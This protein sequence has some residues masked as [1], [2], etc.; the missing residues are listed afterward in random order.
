MAHR[1]HLNTSAAHFKCGQD[2]NSHG[3]KENFV[4]DTRKPIKT[5]NRRIKDAE[6]YHQ[7]F[8]FPD[9]VT[10]QKEF[11]YGQARINFELNA[12]DKDV[13]KTLRVLVEA[14][15]KLKNRPELTGELGAIDFT[16]ICAA[17]NDAEN[18][19]NTVASIRPPG[20]EGPYPA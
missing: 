7:S 14:L 8:N 1:T 16:A 10:Y 9:L 11:S 18:R 5:D 17:L 2:Q 13:L 12:V 4:M 3:G 20:C 6:S 15:E 19:S